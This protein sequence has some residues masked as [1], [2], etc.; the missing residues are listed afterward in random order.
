MWETKDPARGVVEYGDKGEPA[1]RIEENKSSQLHRLRLQGLKPSTKYFYRVG[2][3]RAWS[4]MYEFRSAPALGTSRWRMALYG[5]SRSNPAVHRLIAQRIAAAHVDLILHTGDIVLDG[6]VRSS[7]RHEFFEPLGDLARAVPWLSTIGNHENDL[8]NYLSYVALPGNDRYYG[9]DFANAHF[10]CLDSNGWIEKGRDS[11]QY[12]WLESHLRQPRHATWQFAAFHHGLFSAHAT[13]PINALR[14]EW[15][16][17]LL[18]PGARIDAVLTGHD[19]FYAR[20][21]PMG[22]AAAVPTPGVLFLTSAG[23]GAPIYPSKRWDY[24]AIEKM[25]HHFTL[26]DFQDERI[27]GK[28]IDVSGGIIDEFELAKKPTGPDAFCAYEIEEIKEFIRKALMVSPRAVAPVATRAGLDLELQIPTRF[29]VPVAGELRWEDVPNWSVQAQRFRFQLKPNERLR[30]SARAKVAPGSYPRSPRLT[31]CFDSGLFR[32]RE[33]DFFPWKITSADSVM[34]PDDTSSK[35][36][37]TAAE[38]SRY[39]LVALPPQGGREGSV[40]FRRENDE[41]KVRAELPLTGI[42]PPGT[43]PALNPLALA[44][45]HFRV[46]LVSGEQER[47]FAVSPGLLRY[48]SLNHEQDKTTQWSAA[49]DR[50]PSGRWLAEMTIPLNAFRDVGSLRVN[51]VYHQPVSGGF[52]DY[53]LSPAYEVAG[54]PAPIPDWKS[55]L[56]TQATIPLRLAR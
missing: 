26:L 14:W 43:R 9:Y 51:A 45:E 20:N 52:R 35:K 1:H 13:R 31:I 10:I 5:D 8:N 18:D 16:S 29:Q 11:A 27:E 30:I 38:D 36:H 2:D 15:A 19:H 55:P 17:L 33:I 42:E 7:W 22:R 47:E 21:Y 40:C 25:A 12:R 32:N 44:H 50:H 24:V 6:R 48:A 56:G 53:F 46:V 49:V 39:G 3:E 54:A 28:T 37:D 34:A 41:L 4:P 23:G